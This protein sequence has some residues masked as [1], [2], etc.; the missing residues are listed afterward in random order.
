[1]Q[2]SSQ[3]L[4]VSSVVSRRPNVSH[5]ESRP[6]THAVRQCR[7]GISPAQPAGAMGRQWRWHSMAVLGMRRSTSMCS[8]AWCSLFPHCSP[9][10]TELPTDRQRHR[11]H[12]KT[13][14]TFCIVVHCIV[15]NFPDGKNITI[16]TAFKKMKN[17]LKP[18]YTTQHNTHSQHLGTWAAAAQ[19]RTALH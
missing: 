8:L 14:N 5:V 9:Q 17:I 16:H 19:R 15:F 3:M 11:Q 10:P 6:G 18:N 12:H 2:K 1:M 4:T 7:N 13:H